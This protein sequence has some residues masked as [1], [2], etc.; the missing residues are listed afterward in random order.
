MPGLQEEAPNSALAL[1]GPPPFKLSCSHAESPLK[2]QLSIGVNGDPSLGSDRL[3]S[4]IPWS[5]I[6]LAP[7]HPDPFIGPT[8]LS[9]N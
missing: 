3:T 7:H 8:S 6:S 9:L 5:Q 1:R 2:M 4:P